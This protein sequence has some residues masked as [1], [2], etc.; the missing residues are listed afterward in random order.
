MIS[1]GQS[2]RAASVTETGQ[3]ARPN[4]PRQRHVHIFVL[5][6]ALGWKFLE[7]R[8]Y[9]SHIPAR[10]IRS[11]LALPMSL[12]RKLKWYVNLRSTEAKIQAFAPSVHDDDASELHCK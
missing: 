1:S 3:P 5:I 7:G 12:G 4:G 8:E 11:T 6:D 9:L 2:Q 10:S